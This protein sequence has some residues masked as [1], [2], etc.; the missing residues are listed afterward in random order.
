MERIKQF[1]ALFVN[2]IQ[3]KVLNGVLCS[4]ARYD[5]SILYIYSATMIMG[6][7]RNEE[8]YNF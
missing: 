5:V 2:L 4:V 8:E 7:R 3:L 6:K 1:N